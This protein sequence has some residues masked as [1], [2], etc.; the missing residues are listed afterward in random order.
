MSLRAQEIRMAVSYGPLAILLDELS[1]NDVFDRWQFLRNDSQRKNGNY[2]S[3][4]ELILKFWAYFIKR[5]ELTGSSSRS[6]LDGFFSEQKDFEK[7]RIKKPGVRYYTKDE[8]VELFYCALDD[9]SIFT[10]EDLSPFS[11]PTQSYLEAV[12]VGLVNRKMVLNKPI[13]RDKLIE[14]TKEWRNAL[15]DEKFS[16]LFQARRTSSMTSVNDRITAAIDYFSKDF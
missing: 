10:V 11:K 2:S 1:R 8:F 4:Q 5:N 3:I 6:L 14:F 13:N 7:P 15:G 9:L 12:W 16:E